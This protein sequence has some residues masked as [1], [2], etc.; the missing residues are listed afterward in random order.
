M[1]NSRHITANT[2]NL[3]VPLELLYHAVTILSCRSRKDLAK[4]GG[5]VPSARQNLSAAQIVAILEEE[6][7]GSNRLP[8]LP[9]VPYAVSLSVSTCYRQI[10]HTRVLSFKIRSRKLVLQNL[11]HLK[12]MS[13]YYWSAAVMA[14]L[15][16]KSLVETR[17]LGWG[18][19]REGVTDGTVSLS[20]ARQDLL[21]RDQSRRQ[22]Y[23]GPGYANG[24]DQ[25]LDNNWHSTSM[26]DIDS[27][28]ASQDFA[29]QFEDLDG[30]LDANL[31]LNMP[32]FFP[33]MDT[34][35]F[36]DM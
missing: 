9:Y 35:N 4:P 28:L 19:S 24:D 16:R 33:E 2:H 31:E 36:W 14:E 5:L 21:G 8:L 34:S 32:T 11:R 23:S 18:E 6:V 13:E 26:L 10:R 25:Q 29:S 30:L 22:S 15:A 27:M 1:E 7:P 12:N 20:A 3:P 17:S